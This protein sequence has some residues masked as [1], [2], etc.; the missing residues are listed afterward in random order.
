MF[1]ITQ[2]NAY[3]EKVT[4]T[5]I[6]AII[7]TRALHI[8]GAG[9]YGDMWKEAERPELEATFRIATTTGTNIVDSSTAL[10]ASDHPTIVRILGHYG[11]RLVLVAKDPSIEFFSS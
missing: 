4:F 10:L 11:A 3:M 7:T 6:T 9:E 2:M 1:S 5:T 8:L